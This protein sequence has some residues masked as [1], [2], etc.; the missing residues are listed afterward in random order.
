MTSTAR[1]KHLTDIAK[2]QNSGVEYVDAMEMTHL[3]PPRSLQ[4]CVYWRE[5]IWSHGYW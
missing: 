5:E 2:N 4:I 1:W 3:K